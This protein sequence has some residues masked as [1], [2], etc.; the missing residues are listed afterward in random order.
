MS[1]Y[2]F[3]RNL[4][5]LETTQP[6]A[7]S[8][9]TLNTAWSNIIQRNSVINAMV[10][11]PSLESLQA[12]DAM[13]RQRINAGQ[14][15]NLEGLLIAVK[16][17][18]CTTELT[19]SCASRIL[20]KYKSPFNAT[21]ISKLDEMGAI[22][23]GKTNMD[24]FGMGYLEID[25]RSY[26]LNSLYGPVV[27]PLSGLEPLVS[28]GSSGGSAAAVAAGFCDAALGSDTGGSV[29]LPAAY[30]GVYGFKPSYGRISRFGLI[31]YANSLDTIGIFAKSIQ[32]V[33]KIFSIPSLRF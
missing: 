33:S 13:S 12:K 10:S 29:R 28:G 31:P 26:N 17:N 27:N 30:C 3:R 1:Q 25:S 9:T 6:M 24:E 32:T 4:A 5:E 21:V 11:L 7:R 20:E 19:S 18:I 23:M 14:A 16:D 2:L 15:R 8:Q 22:I